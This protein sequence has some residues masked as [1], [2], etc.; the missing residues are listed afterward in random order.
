LI[1]ERGYAEAADE[2]RRAP[3]HHLTHHVIIV[4]HPSDAPLHWSADG[5]HVRHS[6]RR[7]LPTEVN[8]KGV[9]WGDRSD[10]PCAKRSLLNASEAMKGP[11]GSSLLKF[12]CRLLMNRTRRPLPS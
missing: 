4:P 8:L 10:V 12:G 6:F 5:R 11:P 7:D 9:V 3:D 1:V 2:I